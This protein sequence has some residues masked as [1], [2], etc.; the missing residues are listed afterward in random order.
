VTFDATHLDMYR[1][2]RAQ[3]DIAPVGIPGGFLATDTVRF[4]AKRD[5]TTVDAAAEIGLDAT[6]ASVDIFRVIIPDT[7]TLDPTF[8]TDDIVELYYSVVWIRGSS[9]E[10]VL[11]A[12]ALWVHPHARSG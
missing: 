5:L 12:G 10:T 8:N 11:R 7:E 2:E 4:T 6:F 1:G 3:F 9:D